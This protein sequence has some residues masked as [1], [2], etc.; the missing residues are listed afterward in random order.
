MIWILPLMMPCLRQIRYDSDIDDHII[1]EILISCDK[2]ISTVVFKADTVSSTFVKAVE[3]LDSSH[4]RVGIIMREYL[5]PHWQSCPMIG[6]TI[7]QQLECDIL[8]RRTSRGETVGTWSIVAV[9]LTNG[10]RSKAMTIEG[11]IIGHDRV[12]CRVLMQP[13]CLLG[14]SLSSLLRTGRSWG[15]MR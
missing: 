10:R 2:R 8:G 14:C 3:V 11:H 15:V 13:L 9:G 4:N 1:L 12:T 7:E 5:H 6:G